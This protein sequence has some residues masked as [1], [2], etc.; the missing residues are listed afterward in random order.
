[1]ILIISGPT[2]VNNSLP[3]LNM[4]TWPE[5]KL[6]PA[7]SFLI[8]FSIKARRSA[9][10]LLPYSIYSSS[11]IN[12]SI[13][14]NRFKIFLGSVQVFRVGVN[15]LACG[16]FTQGLHRFLCFYSPPAAPIP[17]A[18][19]AH[20]LD[21]QRYQSKTRVLATSRESSIVILAIDLISP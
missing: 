13:I 9:Y 10:R 14:R 21:A 4:P 3:T 12:S 15:D 17:S 6:H 1:M 20:G 18:A 16:N 8:I 5:R 19:G 11:P 7:I 2:A